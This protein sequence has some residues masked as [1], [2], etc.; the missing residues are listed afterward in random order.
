MFTINI[1]IKFA[2][3][4]VGLLGGILLWS[5]YGLVFAWPVL[6]IG[7]IFLISYLVLGTVQSSA[8]LIQESKFDEAK[9]RLGLTLTPKLLYVT[10]RAIYYIMHGAIAMNDKDM[11]RAEEL[12]ETAKSLKLP[13]DNERGMVLLQ[14]A[15]INAARG[16]WTTA[17]N[18]MRE[19]K[20][21]SIT[22]GPIKNQ[23]TEFE[24]VMKQS[25]QTNAARVGGGK[26]GFR[27]MKGAGGKR[28]RPKMR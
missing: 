8:M 25:G 2:L 21:L 1:Y 16:K 17:K 23:L 7:I 10:N 15:N 5:L 24:K 20:G 28:R 4:A 22:E 6:L 13:S 11:N 19:A 18:Y 26:Q 14:L 27:M 3:I 9:K 12:F